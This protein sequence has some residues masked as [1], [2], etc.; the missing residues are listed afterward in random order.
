MPKFSVVI[1]KQIG[2]TLQQTFT[3]AASDTDEAEDKAM[4]LADIRFAGW[5][6]TEEPDITYEIVEAKEL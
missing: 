2:Q 4:E 5:A 1:E 3:V 6:Q